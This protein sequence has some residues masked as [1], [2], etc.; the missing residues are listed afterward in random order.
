MIQRLFVLLVVV[1]L[2][3]AC[4]QTGQKR[5]HSRADWVDNTPAAV[6][7]QL[8]IEYL[9][10]GMK[11]AALGK[12]HK[13]LSQDPKYPLAHTSIAILYEQL[14]EKNLAETHYKKAH[15]LDGSDPV[16]LNNY[17]Q[18]LCRNGELK[19][20]DS[21]FTAAL[22]DPLYRYPEMVHTNAGI[23]SRQIPNREKAEVHFRKALDVNPRYAPALSQMIRI[24][25]EKENYLATRAYLQ[26]VEEQSKL[27]PEFLWVGVQSEAK[28]GNKDAAASYA[29]SLK[30]L[31]PTST[32]AGAL[33]KWEKDPGVH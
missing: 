5:L 10:K 30:N 15:Q 21:M 3:A 19:K 12:L 13:A 23:C 31:Y 6:N 17:G 25:F 33:L 24:S 29:L 11:E 14:G 28:L 4:A 7:T 9:K 1:G 27:T 22:E 8:G 2:L 26:R 18:F 20:A 16:N 32:Q